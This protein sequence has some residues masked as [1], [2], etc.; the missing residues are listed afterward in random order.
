MKKKELFL[1]LGLLLVTCNLCLNGMKKID[2]KLSR[3]NNK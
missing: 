3:K 2:K 1:G